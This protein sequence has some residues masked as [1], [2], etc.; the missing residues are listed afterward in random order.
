MKTVKWRSLFITSFVCLLPI[1]LGLA[2]WKELPQR[3]AIHFNIY[4]QPDR[5]ASKEFAVF[6]PPVLMVFFQIFC[7]VVTDL[8]SKEYGGQKIE[9]IT[10]WIL[11][12]ITVIL[13]VVIFLFALEFEIEIRRV[14]A[15]LIG[16]ILIVT[17]N[18]LPKLNYVKNKK[19]TSEKARKIN[20]FFGIESV[21]MGLLFLLSI[22]FPPVATVICLFLLL[23]VLIIGGIYSKK[24]EKE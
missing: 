20:R 10:K 6:G 1:L 5:F 4:N 18:Y 21:I 13:Q 15:A 19:L 14:V 9:G 23:P 8:N 24:T 2:L 22:F 17:G 7:C 3:I 16:G 12:V 11:P